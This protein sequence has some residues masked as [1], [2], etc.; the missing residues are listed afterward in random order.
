MLRAM[1][2]LPAPSGSLAVWPWYMS[3]ARALKPSAAKRS[4]TFLMCG[5]RP[6]HSWMTITPGPL[7]PGGVARYPSVV[8]PLVANFTILPAMVPLLL[9]VLIRAA[10]GRR[11]GLLSLSGRPRPRPRWCDLDRDDAPAIRL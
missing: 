8:V 10:G 1:K 7:P 9:S 2:S 6:H 3:G 4:H 11:A 5:T